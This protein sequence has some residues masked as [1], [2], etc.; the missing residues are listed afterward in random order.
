MTQ[1][2]QAPSARPQPSH[3]PNGKSP[4]VHSSKETDDYFHTVVLIH[5]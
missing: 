5:K 3:T 2:E 1:A 4:Q